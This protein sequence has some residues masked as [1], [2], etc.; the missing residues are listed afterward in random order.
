VLP[1]DGAVEGASAVAG[2]AVAAAPPLKEQ[3]V[4]PQNLPVVPAGTSTV[5]VHPGSS[6][7]PLLIGMAAGHTV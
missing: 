5:H 7:V 6:C 4:R 1:R 3:L 2:V